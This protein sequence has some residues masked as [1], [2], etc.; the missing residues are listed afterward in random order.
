M[1]N[2]TFRPGRPQCTDPA[3][4]PLAVGLLYPFLCILLRPI[5]VALVTA[6]SS[7][8]DIASRC[9]C[10]RRGCSARSG[11]RERT[12]PLPTLRQCLCW[13]APDAVPCCCDIWSHCA[14]IACMS[15]L[16]AAPGR[17]C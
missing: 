14:I 7:V 6:L 17:I 2:A 8:S 3:E 10:G 16:I 9:G 13:P 12:G 1:P 4:I 11:L 15:G 5:I